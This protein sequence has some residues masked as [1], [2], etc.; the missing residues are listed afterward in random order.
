MKRDA[1]RQV[2][3]EGEEPEKMLHTKMDG[4][5]FPPMPGSKPDGKNFGSGPPPSGWKPPMAAIS[6]VKNLKLDIPYANE[7]EAQ[8]LDLYYPEQGDGPFPALLHIHGGGFAFGNKRDDH[9]DAYLA[10]IR[11]GY[12]VG[13]IGYRLSGEATFPA[14][15]LDVREAIRFVRKH[16]AKYRIDPD[17][18]AVIGGSAGGNLTA[19]LAM[20]IPNGSFLSESETENFNT[21]PYVQ[22]AIDQ[23]G[24]TDFR[25]MDAQARANGIS[26]ADHDRPES[27]ESK[28]IGAPIQEADPALCAAANPV[29][30]ISDAMCP[31][32]IE[33]GRMDRLV[34][35]AQSETLY[36]AICEILGDGRAEFVPLDNAD[37]E[38]KEFTE[39]EN[40]QRIWDFLG[41]N[42]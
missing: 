18:I 25:S 29:T 13:S 19:L 28:Y 14:A 32:L 2:P 12:V 16:A 41:K 15:V 37:H 34:P 30:Y 42:L 11:R 35:F 10:G 38:D 1:F 21:V 9:M 20:N 3:P 40:M 24:P 5:P 39:A 17:R 6:W 22:V 4:M 31:L 33:H 23:F 7:S 8:Q 36:K 26:F 27:P